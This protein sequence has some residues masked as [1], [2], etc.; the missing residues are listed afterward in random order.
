MKEITS[1]EDAYFNFGRGDY[2]YKIQN[3]QP[4]TYQLFNIVSF[5]TRFIFFIGFNFNNCL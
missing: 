3:F 1:E 4:D 2:N 5:F